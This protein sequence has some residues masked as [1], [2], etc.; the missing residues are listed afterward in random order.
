MNEVHTTPAPMEKVK[1]AG[2]ARLA[3][4]KRTTV[5]R[6]RERTSN[7]RKRLLLYMALA[8]MLLLLALFALVYGGLQLAAQTN[9]ANPSSSN[10][11]SITPLAKV[12]PAVVHTYS[13]FPS[14]AG[15]MLPVVDG[16]GFVWFGEMETNHLARLDPRT[17]AVKTWTP[18]GGEYGIMTNVTDRQGKVWFTEQNANY[19]AVFDPTRQ[20]FRTFG[21]GTGKQHRVGLQ[22]LQFDASGKLWF[23]EMTGRRIGRLDPASGRIQTWDLPNAAGGAVTYPFGLSITR[24]GQVWFGTFAGGMLGHLDPKTGQ[25]K[26]Y[27]LADPREQVYAMAGDG[28][29]RIWFTELQF[30]KLGMIDTTTGKVIELTVPGTLG[31]PEDLHSVVVT[32]DGNVWF[33]SSGTN[34]LVRYSPKNATFTFFQIPL[35]YSG[36]FGLAADAAGRLWFTAGG[37]QQANYIGVMAL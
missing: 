30:G 18:P 16:Q 5:N 6:R 22:D 13:V 26:L 23:T 10:T 20:T 27:T 4:G 11:V 21:F 12:Q 3:K 36:L 34:S 15:L 19:I 28:Q 29:G 33:T 37:G 24:N 14:N 32:P 2:A 17:G 8:G 25:I 31:N 9:G 1:D 7:H 35:P